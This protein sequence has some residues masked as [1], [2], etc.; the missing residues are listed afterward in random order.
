MDQYRPNVGEMIAGGSAILLSY[1][2]SLDWFAVELLNE[3][4][5]LSYVRYFIPGKSAWEGLDYIPVVLLIAIIA[6]LAVP[7]LPTKA[8]RKLPV[9]VHLVVA[10][11]GVVSALLI[12]YRIVDPPSF[13]SVQ[14]SFGSAKGE[15]EIQLP[16]FLSLLAAAGIAFGGFWAMREEGLREPSA[17]DA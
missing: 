2:M 9:S 14:T 5:L 11:L 3:S 17:A 4:N 8:I 13:D 1:F 6:A 15:G 12:L 7:A 16:I 10:F